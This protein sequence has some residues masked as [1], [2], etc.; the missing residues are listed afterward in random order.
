ME[1]TKN[2]KTLV[3]LLA[4]I[5]I[6]NLLGVAFFY[7]AIK[8]TSFTLTLFIMVEVAYLI[9]II[10]MWNMNKIGLII[11]YVIWGLEIILS[12]ISF[13]II[14]ILFGALIFYNLIKIR[15]DYFQP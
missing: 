5:F 2:A 7:D 8:F 1:R 12:L 4:V 10:L 11:H 3:I 9:G 14:G 6:L 15:K 13:N